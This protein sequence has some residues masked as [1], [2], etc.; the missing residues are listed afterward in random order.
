MK[1]IIAILACAIG[2]TTPG[3]EPSKLSGS[4]IGIEIHFDNNTV[5]A[6]LKEGQI[7][8]N[9]K[10]TNNSPKEVRLDQ[11]D[12]RS[13]GVTIYGVDKNGKTYVLFPTEPSVGSG[14]MKVPIIG[15]HKSIDFEAKFPVRIV[16][17][18]YVKFLVMINVWQIESHKEFQ[19]YSEPFSLPV[20]F[21][22]LKRRRANS[23]S[24][25][26]ALSGRNRYTS[27]FN[28]MTS[29]FFG[30]SSQL[31][32]Q[33]TMRSQ[34]FFYST[35]WMPQGFHSCFLHQTAILL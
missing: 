17:P 23:R 21:E 19:I 11:N 8:I 12:D 26:V 2:F 5:T 22:K 7:P 32:T 28:S 18:L 24:Y 31:C 4:D 30:H 1:F 35:K 16:A 15:V 13:D 9:I 20:Y 3:Q 27:F 10:V 25:R 14:P 6:A 34:P 29:R 33:Q